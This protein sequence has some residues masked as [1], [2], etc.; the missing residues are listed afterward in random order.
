M[1]EAGDGGD[2]GDDDGAICRWK[3]NDCTCALCCAHSIGTAVSATDVS[4]GGSSSNSNSSANIIL[5]KCY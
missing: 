5:V 3:Y 1:N 4:D 2:D